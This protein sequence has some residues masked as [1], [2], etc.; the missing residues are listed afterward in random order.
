MVPRGTDRLSVQTVPM[1]VFQ[2]EFF[3]P[4]I[5]ADSEKACSA[6]AGGGACGVRRGLWFRGVS[7]LANAFRK[8]RWRCAAFLAG[9]EACGACLGLWFQGMP[10]LADAPRPG[11]APCQEAE[12]QHQEKQFSPV[13]LRSPLSL[14][15]QAPWGRSACPVVVPALVPMGDDHRRPA[16]PEVFP[17]GLGKGHRAV[18]PAG[19]A[20]GDGQAALPLLQV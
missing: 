11:G 9:G 4:G 14:S 3:F 2:Q 1:A 10:R 18:A 13:H 16:F 6:L 5:W 8:I 7:R 15:R 12:G 19:A 20:H 17:D